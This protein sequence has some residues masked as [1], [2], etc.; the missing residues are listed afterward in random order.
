VDWY[1]PNERLIDPTI[2]NEVF[3]LFGNRR[4]PG[5]I[6]QILPVSGVY[7]GT[8]QLQLLARDRP[9]T[10]IARIRFDPDASP[11]P[12]NSTVEVRMHYTGFSARVANVLV[13]LFVLLNRTLRERCVT[14][15]RFKSTNRCAR[16]AAPKGWRFFRYFI[17]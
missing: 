14:R 4:I 15:C 13:R 8:Q 1:I 10:Q 17:T 16:L 11:P 9:A 7:A 5:K 6:A 2:G 12:L 3:V